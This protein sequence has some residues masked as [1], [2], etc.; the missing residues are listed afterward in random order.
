MYKR[1]ILITALIDSALNYELTRE[2]R[3]EDIGFSIIDSYRTNEMSGNFMRQTFPIDTLQIDFYKFLKLYDRKENQR[4]N[5]YLHLTIMLR[6]YYQSLSGK[7]ELNW[8]DELEQQIV[9]ELG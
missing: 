2:K 8:I 4:K 3:F 5:K 9:K 1:Q 7:K 6:S